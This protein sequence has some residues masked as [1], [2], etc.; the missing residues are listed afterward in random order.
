MFIS[1]TRQCENKI[2]N[3]RWRLGLKNCRMQVG[4]GK[5]AD[6]ALYWDEQVEIKIM[7]KGPRYFDV[8]I[9]DNQNNLLWRA[10]F[11]Y[12]EPK[13]LERHHMWRALHRLKPNAN[14]PWLVIGDFNETMW[15]HEHFSETKRSERRMSDY[16]NLLA[17]C[18]VYDLGFSGPAWNFDNKQ[19]G[20]RNVKACLDR[21]V[22]SDNWL[23]AFPDAKVTN[24]IST[25]S[26]HLPV[27]LDFERAPF[28]AVQ[29]ELP[30][31][32]HMWV[33]DPA[34]ENIIEE[35]WTGTT[36][37]SN[38]GDLANKIN[39]TRGHLGEWNTKNFRNIAKQIK[40][41]RRKWKKPKSDACDLAIGKY[42]TELDELLQREETHW[43]QRSRINW[44]REGDRNTK[45][46]HKKATWRQTKNRIKRVDLLHTWVPTHPSFNF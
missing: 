3:H 39:S 18:K 46:F 30:K 24:I 42:N 22:T 25:R 12:G 43:R 26:Y 34:L 33:R 2:K 13:S 10:T 38:L 16:R 28:Q 21:A 11:V 6:I 9:R 36:P 19:K 40:K 14:E 5:G 31:Y 1:E 17:F 7:S 29:C 4:S 35:A 41:L 15:Q 44:L 37:C 32:E 8:L 23:S 20:N 27:L 45:Y